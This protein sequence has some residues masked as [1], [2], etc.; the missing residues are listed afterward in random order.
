ME[1]MLQF[2]NG[3]EGLNGR[4]AKQN[5]EELY[6]AAQPLRQDQSAE[7]ADAKAQRNVATTVRASA[8]WFACGCCCL[9]CLLNM[10]AK[11]V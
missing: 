4:V 8:F 7:S 5:Q 3:I 10:C 9:D 2:L 6:I 11:C 1:T